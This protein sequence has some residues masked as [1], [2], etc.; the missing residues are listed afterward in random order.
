MISAL[1]EKIRFHN[2]RNELNFL[3][4]QVIELES[5][6]EDCCLHIATNNS[7]KLELEQH[8]ILIESESSYFTNQKAQLDLAIAET[9]RQIRELKKKYK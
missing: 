7:K 4:R 5:R 1:K 6:Q 8:L 2:Y 3:R 9:Y